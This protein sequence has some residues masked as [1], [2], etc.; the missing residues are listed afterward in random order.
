MSGVF[1]MAAG[2]ISKAKNDKLR[3]SVQSQPKASDA[4]PPT[5][6]QFMKIMLPKIRECDL[7]KS[8]FIDTPEEF[9]KV[10]KLYGDYRL[11]IQDYWSYQKCV[12]THSPEYMGIDTHE[13]P[14]EGTRPPIEEHLDSEFWPSDGMIAVPKDRIYANAKKW[15]DELDKKMSICFNV[16]VEPVE[17]N[18]A[19]WYKPWAKIYNYDDIISGLYSNYLKQGSFGRVNQEIKQKQ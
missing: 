17:N 7:D 10:K 18:R 1:K 6:D 8:G 19:P 11:Y 12:V 4:P 14:S 3:G 5:F 15:S 16:E 13:T 9:A 2:G